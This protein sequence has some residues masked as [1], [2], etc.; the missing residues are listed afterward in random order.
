MMKWNCRVYKDPDI[1][2]TNIWIRL[3]T[4][5]YTLLITSIKIPEIYQMDDVVAT[6]TFQVFFFFLQKLQPIYGDVLTE[7]WDRNHF[8]L[9]IPSGWNDALEHSLL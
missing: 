9:D 3:N 1:I 4:S 2:H 7:Y 6:Y 8:L 5:E